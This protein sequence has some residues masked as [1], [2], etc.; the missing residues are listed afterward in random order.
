MQIPVV[1]DETERSREQQR[2][3]E[4]MSKS[5]PE[6]TR[7]NGTGRRL[8]RPGRI[9][10]AEDDAEMASLLVGAL[11][12][13]GYETVTCSDGLQL[14]R[15]LKF[16]KEDGGEEYDLVISDI[17]MPNVSGLDVLRA[18]SYGGEF[19]PVILITAF[20]DEWTHGKARYLGAIDVFDKPFDIGELINR[21]R[22]IVPPHK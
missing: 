17:R 5:M 11:H 1:T 6:R 16:T 21:V 8:G 15:R 4:I 12:N 13:A 19:P 10:L 14:L 22:E 3:S 9:L 2:G 7:K 20:G 18:E